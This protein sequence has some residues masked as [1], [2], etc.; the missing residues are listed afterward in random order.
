MTAAPQ[1][2]RAVG[3]VRVSQTR[4]REEEE[5]FAFPGVQRDRIKDV[6]EREG[7]DLLRTHDEMERS[8][9]ATRPT[10]RSRLAWSTRSST[11]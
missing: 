10:P 11:A 8:G 4:G 2:K 7:I 3:I 1:L 9:G 6:C 5:G